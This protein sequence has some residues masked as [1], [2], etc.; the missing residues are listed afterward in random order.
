MIQY[1]KVLI[2]CIKMFKFR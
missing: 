2:R 1:P